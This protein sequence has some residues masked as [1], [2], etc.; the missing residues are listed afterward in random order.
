MHFLDAEGLLHDLPGQRGEALP[1]LDGRAQHGRDTVVD[2]HR[3]RGHLV[4]AFRAEH[5]HHA[6]AVAHTAAY[7][8]GFA[9]A[10]GAA[11]QQPLLL[12]G[13]LR[14]RRQREVPYGL[15]EFGDRRR[16]GHG[17]PGRQHVTGGHHIAQAQLRRVDAE[18]LRELV[19]LRL[20]R[21]AHL[22]RALAAH[23]PGGRIVGAYGPAL[24]EGVRHDVGAA[25]EGDGGGE[26]VGGGV[27]V[28]ARVEQD[29]RLDLDESALGVG[30]VPV[31]QQG[32]VAVGVAE[33]GL[34]ARSG[35]FHRT[36]G[37]QREQAERQLEGAVLAVGGG[38]RH[39]GDDDFD[40][41]GFQRVAGG[42]RVAVAVRVGGGGVQL[43]AA[44]GAGHGEAGLGADGCGV[45]AADAVQAL[46]DDLADGLRVAV[47]QRDVPDQVAV[48]VQRLRLEGLFGVGDGVED[49]V[50]DDDGRCGHPRGVGV[51]GG[52]GGDGL[53]VVAYDVGGEDGPVG[54]APSVDGG[55]R[56]RPRG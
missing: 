45:L 38:A 55:C 16:A 37:L 54:A 13:V 32:G 34:L 29:L 36:A 11:G 4:G 8:A 33:E 49:V 6:D 50:L 53:A 43:D 19:H 15:Q 27:G 20:V 26:R 46:D 14:Q 2:L 30:V 25:G 10:F 31:A 52:D 9:R 17:L 42:E 18:L 12:R 1:G 22:H 51:V 35:E 24:D 39:A 7:G 47:T 41:L 44:V 23:M 3:G 40:P 5:V 48:G 56:G 21:G 28:G